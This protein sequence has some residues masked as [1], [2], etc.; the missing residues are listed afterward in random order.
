MSF[1]WSEEL[2]LWSS[3]DHP[4]QRRGTEW[5]HV[6]YGY[7]IQKRGHRASWAWKIVF[8]EHDELVLTD[9]GSRF[10]S[11]DISD[12]Q[13]TLSHRE[14]MMLREAETEEIAD[15]PRLSSDEIIQNWIDET[16]RLRIARSS[17]TYD[18]WDEE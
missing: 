16:A 2:M 14:Y 13:Y 8:N 11:M 15:E 7:R 12:I 10:W 5:Y 9:S 1:D 18:G 3:R 17:N 4:T 6:E